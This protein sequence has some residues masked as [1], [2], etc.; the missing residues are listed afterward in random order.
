VDT[1]EPKQRF[2]IVCEGEKT[3]PAYFKGFRVSKVVIKVFGIGANTIGVVEA[4]IR[5]KQ[6]DDFDQVWCVFDRDEFPVENFNRALALAIEND[7]AVAYSNEAFE[8]WY[9]LH[10]DYFDSAIR[11]RDYQ[12]RLTRYLGHTYQKNNGNMYEELLSRQDTAIKNAKRLFDS[13]VPSCPSDD[14]P[15]TTVH[16]LVNKLN[17]YSD[18]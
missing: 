8:L 6:E 9:L 12:D 14:N 18:K 13:Y 3:E 5:L 16:D 15:S 1:R 4:A 17:E 2:L 7:I 10:F 11:R